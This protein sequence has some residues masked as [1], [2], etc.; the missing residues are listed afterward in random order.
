MHI[1]GHCELLFV[2]KAPFPSVS[3]RLQPPLV[4]FESSVVSQLYRWLTSSVKGPCCV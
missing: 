4:D 1:I 2:S 3:V